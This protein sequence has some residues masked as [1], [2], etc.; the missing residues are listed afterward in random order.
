MLFPLWRYW[1]TLCVRRVEWK[2]LRNLLI[3]LLKDIVTIEHNNKM[4]L[5]A[6]RMTGKLT[7]RKYMIN[8]HETQMQ[9]YGDKQLYRSKTVKK[10]CGCEHM[11][12]QRAFHERNSR[13]QHKCF[14]RSLKE[15][16]CFHILYRKS[17]ASS[18]LKHIDTNED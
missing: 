7:I 1:E 14:G 3:L 10:K 2:D 6:E 17:S 15:T 13:R 5:G 16:Y 11:V 12:A 8:K 9:M 18:N 4:L